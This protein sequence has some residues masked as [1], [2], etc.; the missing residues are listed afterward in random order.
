MKVR[1]LISLLQQM[2]QEGTVI[3]A[4]DNF[5]LNYNDVPVT[6]CHQS[7][8]GS[9]QVRKFRDAFDGGTYNTETW[10]IIGGKETVV[11]LS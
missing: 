9:K 6:Y 8:E 1:E 10:S 4:S 11:K 3:V 7:V 5:E 2:D